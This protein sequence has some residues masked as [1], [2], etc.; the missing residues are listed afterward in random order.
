MTN[1]GCIPLMEIIQNQINNSEMKAISFYDY[2]SLCLY[3]SEYGYYVKDQTKIGKEG[4]FYTSSSIGT[5]MGET[6]AHYIS[7]QPQA[8]DGQFFSLVEWGGGTGRLAKHVLDELQNNHN[9]LY[10]LINFI[11]IEESIFHKQLQL[12]SLTKHQGKVQFVTSGEWFNDKHQENVI[13]FSNELLDAFPVHR[14]I[15][16]Q[17]E[18]YEIFVAWDDVEQIFIEKHIKCTDPL[19]LS[20]IKDENLQLNQGQKF[21][22]NT[23]AKEWMKKLMNSL[24]SATIITIDYGDLKDE[25]YSA[26]RME[27]TLM[28]YYKHQASQQPYSHVGEQD[29]TSHVNFSSC[30]SVGENMGFNHSYM[31]QKE[32]L[33]QSGILNKLQQHNITD[34][35][36]PIVKKNRAIRQLLLSDQM[37]ELFKVLIQKKGF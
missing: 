1:I 26:H 20:Y 31:T 11:S 32:F 3:H 8:T 2:M 18:Y 15:Y 14:L 5:I 19:L 22:I 9:E 36:H 34:P 28:C 37:S 27:G 25:I 6:I 7:T 23:A 33:F 17:E 16:N 21:E 13:L 4:D 12:Q 35:F 10:E 30:I 24:N 29:I